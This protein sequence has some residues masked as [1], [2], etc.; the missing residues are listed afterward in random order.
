M[1]RF[2]NDYFAKKTALIIGG[3]SS[4]GFNVSK[5]LAARGAH[6]LLVS[7]DSVE[8]QHALDALDVHGWKS[9]ALQ[10]DL[11]DRESVDLLCGTVRNRFGV[12]DIIVF[13]AGSTHYQSALEVKAT[14]AIQFMNLRYGSTMQILECFLE[15]LTSQKERAHLVF[16]T[17]IFSWLP[18]RFTS[19]SATDHALKSL[20]KTLHF[21]FGSKGLH[22]MHAEIPLLQPVTGDLTPFYE[23]TSRLPRWVVAMAVI[24]QHM[25]GIIV[26]GI[27]NQRRYA[28]TPAIR[29][30][31]F[32]YLHAGMS[33]MINFWNRLDLHL[34]ME[35]PSATV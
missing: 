5:V 2:S 11:T 24:P 1:K 8:L 29:F 33:R 31:R 22:V 26:R 16:V 23:R 3:S 19:H 13:A 4:V 34:R 21:E 7:N 30:I 32:L 6:V 20:A 9:S 14:D 25:A 28:A 35:K 27:E 15:D 17:G 18:F 10:A 12:P